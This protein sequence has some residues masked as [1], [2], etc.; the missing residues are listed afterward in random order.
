M[1]ALLDRANLAVVTTD[2]GAAIR[3]RFDAL[4]I[5]EREWHARTGIDRKTLIRAMENGPNVRASTYAAIES[6][7]DKLEARVDGRPTV[8]P[9]GDPADDLMEVVVEGNFGVRAVVKGPVRDKD[10]LQEFVRNLI[11]DMNR[12][13]GE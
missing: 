6:N 7:L 13:S 5:S 10:A 4:G 12:D 2:R 11:A 9:V 3:Q 8:Q 1:S